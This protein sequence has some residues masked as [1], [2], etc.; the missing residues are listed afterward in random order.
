MCTIVWDTLES[1][2]PCFYHFLVLLWLIKLGQGPAKPTILKMRPPKQKSVC[3]FTQS[4]SSLNL[5]LNGLPRN[6]NFF[7]RTATTQTSRMLSWPVFVVRTCLCICCTVYIPFHTESEQR[8]NDA[9]YEHHCDIIFQ[10]ASIVFNIGVK[11]RKRTLFNYVKWLQKEVTK[12][13][14]WKCVLDNKEYF[15]FSINYIRAVIQLCDIA[16]RYTC[17]MHGMVKGCN[18][19]F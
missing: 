10:T 1:N 14:F 8:R 9:R 13:I 15:S 18:L 16:F 17:T 11:L 7:M 19:E 5:A 2:K 3:A 12:H 6:R 4:D